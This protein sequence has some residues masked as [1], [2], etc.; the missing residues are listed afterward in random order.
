MLARK[1]LAHDGGILLA[2]GDTLMHA[3][4]EFATATGQVLEGDG[5]QPDDIMARTRADAEAEYDPALEAALAW[6][7]SEIGR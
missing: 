6:I 3:I 7:T 2:D 1:C 4:G 5:V